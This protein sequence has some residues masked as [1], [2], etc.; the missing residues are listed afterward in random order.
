MSFV[1]LTV[2]MSSC[3]VVVR[4]E[5]GAG[6]GGVCRGSEAVLQVLRQ[7]RIRSQSKPVARD[8]SGA[9][10]GSGSSLLTPG[11]TWPFHALR[12]PCVCLF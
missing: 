12:P 8:K 6:W 3:S 4:L 10:K 7:V 5:G 1:L 9:S 11:D 2:V